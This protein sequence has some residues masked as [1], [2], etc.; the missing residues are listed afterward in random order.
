MLEQHTREPGVVALPR[1]DLIPLV[2]FYTIQ[3]SQLQDGG[4]SLVGSK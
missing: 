2:Q 3:L 4:L 1:T